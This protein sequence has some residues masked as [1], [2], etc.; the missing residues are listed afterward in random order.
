MS[1]LQWLNEFFEKRNIS[2]LKPDGRPL[3]AYRCTLDE[4]KS[5]KSLL[6]EQKEQTLVQQFI[7]VTH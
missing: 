7:K 2:E 5:L 6:V 3:F 4:Y 1:A